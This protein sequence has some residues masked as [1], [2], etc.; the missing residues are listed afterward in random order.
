MS[1]SGVDNDTQISVVVTPFIPFSAGGGNTALNAAARASYTPSAA[2]Q[3]T[4]DSS[5]PTHTHTH[6]HTH[7]QCCNYSSSQQPLVP[8][9]REQLHDCQPPSPPPL[10]AHSQSS[11]T[12]THRHTYL[13]KQHVTFPKVPSP[14]VRRISSE[15]SNVIGQ[16]VM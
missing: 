4:A 9:I 5:I 11:H 14:S 1:S 2:S 8:N 7:T 16:L 13:S 10:T 6:T 3:H 15:T 12:H